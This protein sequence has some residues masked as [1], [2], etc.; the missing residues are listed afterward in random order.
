MLM[1]SFVEWLNYGNFKQVWENSI[2]GTNIEEECQVVENALI[3]SEQNF[4]TYVIN[5]PSHTVQRLNN[6]FYFS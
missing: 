1:A 2:A 3:C 4:N 5:T 6:T